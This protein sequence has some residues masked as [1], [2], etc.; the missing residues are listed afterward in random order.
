MRN[1]RKTKGKIFVKILAFLWRGL[2]YPDVFLSGCSYG[3]AASV[4]KL[5]E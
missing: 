2:T 1:T 3:V 5:Q 4:A